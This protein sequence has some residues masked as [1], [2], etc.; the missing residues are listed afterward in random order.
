M[1]DVRSCGQCG[2]IMPDDSP[3]GICP[4]CLMRLGMGA[5]NAAGTQ[6]HQAGRQQFV[7]PKPHELSVHFPQLEILD[8][9]F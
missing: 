5:Q 4:S 1:S 8:L 3:N 7:A 6:T 9:K 2:V